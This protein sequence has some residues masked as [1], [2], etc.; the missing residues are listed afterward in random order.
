VA[1][2]FGGDLNHLGSGCVDAAKLWAAP[3]L[4]VRSKT[5]LLLFGLF[6]QFGDLMI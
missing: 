5:K 2:G 6:I 1:V 4:P 3:P